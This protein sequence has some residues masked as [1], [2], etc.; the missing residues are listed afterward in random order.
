MSTFFRVKKGLVSEGTTILSGSLLVKQPATFNSIITGSIQFAETASIA[1]TASY[2]ES[3]SYSES[4]SFST[5]SSY[6]ETSSY[7]ES[8]SFAVSSSYSQTASYAL[9]FDP[10]VEVFPNNS[11]IKGTYN[12]S[13]ATIPGT[14]LTVGDIPSR[15]LPTFF[16]ADRGFNANANPAAGMLVDNVNSGQG[17]TYNIVTNGYVQIPLAPEI[18]GSIQ[19]G[20][21]IYL[22]GFNGI[23][24][25]YF[26]ATKPTGSNIQKVG[27]VL[28]FSGSFVNLYVDIVQ[29]WDE[30][31]EAG[32]SVLI[33]A[34]APVSQSAGTLWFNTDSDSANGGELYIQLSDSGSTWIPVVDKNVDQAVSSSFAVTASIANSVKTTISNE[35]KQHNVLFVDTTGP[36][37]VQIDGGIRYNPNTN[38]LT[39]TASFAQK[40]SITS[41]I[42]DQGSSGYMDI[43]SVRYQWGVRTGNVSGGA[44][45]LP[46]AF[47][48][49][50]YAVTQTMVVNNPLVAFSSV[51]T[52]KTLTTFNWYNTYV[53]DISFGGAGEPFSWIAIGLKP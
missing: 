9:N 22:R 32:A 52:G 14:L 45:T 12:A 33:S 1:A 29:E 7:V 50:N 39:T 26:T 17:G 37:N 27:K 34:S 15:E 43:G 8:S 4:S 11:T 18:S 35:N 40:A 47:A 44:V 48:N 16:F 51:T 31:V 24:F 41:Q 20:D 30:E 28:D 46:A 23:R 6:S 49:T 3:S 25:A 5:T 2:V 10:N 38:L 42:N 36:G 19:K 13:T 21:D 53:N